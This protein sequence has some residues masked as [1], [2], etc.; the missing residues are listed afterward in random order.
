MFDKK[1]L[2]TTE[3]G[4]SLTNFE[5]DLSA[6]S[7]EFSDLRIDLTEVKPEI[8]KDC[9]LTA[10]ADGIPAGSL[11]NTWVSEDGELIA[12]YLCNNSNQGAYKYS[13]I[14]GKI[15]PLLPEQGV[16]TS[17]RRRQMQPLA[18]YMERNRLYSLLTSPAET[19]QPIIVK[20]KDRQKPIASARSTVPEFGLIKGFSLP[21][22]VHQS[23]RIEAAVRL[24]E[25]GKLK[26]VKPASDD[27]YYLKS[28]DYISFLASSYP[29]DETPY[30]AEPVEQTPHSH[31]EDNQK[32]REKA[33]KDSNLKDV[34]IKAP[35]PARYRASENYSFT[36]VPARL[37]KERDAFKRYP[38][39]EAAEL[40]FTL[41]PTDME[42]GNFTDLKGKQ[43]A[44]HINPCRNRWCFG[45]NRSGKT[46]CGAVEV[47]YM[48]LGN[49]PYRDNKKNTTGWVVSL[50]RQ[51]QR[52]VAQE[53]ILHY[54]PPSSIKQVVMATGSKEYLQSGMID[55]IMVENAF[56]G[57]SK[58]GFRNCEQGREKFQGASL[59][60]VWFDEEPP[61]EIYNECKMRV[62][63]KVG[64]IFG[65]M[66]P[67]KG[68]TWVYNEIYLNENNNKDIWSQHI[69][70]E[71]NPF[72]NEQEVLNLT[73]TMS[74]DE[75]QA[76]KFGKFINASG[77]VYTEFDENINVIEPFLVPK[78]WYDNICIDPGLHNPLSCH[79]YAEDYDGNIYVIAEHYEAQQN[80]T[81]HS[82]KIKEIA[83]RLGWE[84]HNG[85]LNA[86]I[87]S[88]ANQRTLASEK[89]VVELFYENQILA[90][91]RV[92]KDMFSGISTVKSYLKSADGTSKLFI[93]KNCVNMIR[94]IKSYWWGNQD[95]P[96]KKDDHALD[97][98]R[99]YLMDKK[100]Q[101]KKTMK[102]EKNIIQQHKEK[103]MRKNKNQFLSNKKI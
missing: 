84:K 48:A 40:S 59:D 54:L 79:F 78:E 94:E 47:V 82:N 3:N 26:K 56:G 97:E 34:Q 50:S 66:T 103:L 88:A 23:T 74:K 27:S 95:A 98:L 65:T 62:F 69:Q 72:L 22:T 21:K 36:P 87:D 29:Q 35:S 9:L 42:L 83:N 37:E 30:N 19:Q 85:Y 17:M 60:Y 55:F 25:Q 4:Q 43:L 92:N 28:E 77:M 13:Y 49:H 2:L 44:F 64:D 61:Y 100:S 89:N 5:L 15:A 24:R 38:F 99:Y 90:N 101:F 8:A 58:I 67:L 41:T 53:K 16:V 102:P 46:E 10:N 86:L 70:W 63:D 45:G 96:I 32:E 71:D 51:V 20:A 12:S 91:P 93:F 73:Q 52:D 18:G 33:R 6:L 39:V 75:L 7:T 14:L 81:H 31:Q 1:N 76:R 11:I 57:L 68:L 80:I